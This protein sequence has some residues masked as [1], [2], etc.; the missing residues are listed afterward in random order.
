MNPAERERAVTYLEKTRDDYYRAA[1][2]LSPN[3]LRFKPAADRWSIA[4]L[5]EHIIIVEGRVNDRFEKVL[6]QPP[7]ESRSSMAD[8][9]LV[10]LTAER[11]NKLQAPEVV[12][13]SGRW[14]DDHLLEEFATVRNRSIEFA[15]TT[16]ADLRRH[17]MPHPFFGQL[18]CYQY[19]LLLS[20]HCE[21]HLAQAEEVM[22]HP[23]FPRAVTAL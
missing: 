17:S 8:D 6:A 16:N 9:Q 2:G 19:L 1:R 20:A 13:P 11:T 15:R 23:N 10:R 5:F 3:Q 14:P 12:S 22:A 4:E 21:R 18:D 7:G